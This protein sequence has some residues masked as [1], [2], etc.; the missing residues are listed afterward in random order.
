MTQQQDQARDSIGRFTEQEHSTPELA[1]GEAYLEDDTTGAEFD[2]DEFYDAHVADDTDMA[3][4]DDEWL[5]R[6]RAE[7][8]LAHMDDFFA[9]P[10]PDFEAGTVNIFDPSAWENTPF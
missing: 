6:Q 10:E 1:L 2:I 9:R 5:E 3:V 7:R 4:T 8:D